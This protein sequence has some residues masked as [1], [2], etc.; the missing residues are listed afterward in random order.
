MLGK[1]STSEKVNFGCEC[2][3]PPCWG[4][5]EKQDEPNCQQCMQVL[6][7]SLA[8]DECLDS[9]ATSQLLVF[10][11]GVDEDL[12]VTQKLASLYSMNDT[13]TGEDLF[14][15]LKNNRPL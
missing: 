9:C 3:F 7:F 1:T 14:S 4:H 10:V 15:E 13:V 8:T 12:N 5:G 6:P 2:C 11:R